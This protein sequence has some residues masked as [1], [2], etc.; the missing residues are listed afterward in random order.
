[1]LAFAEV[2][3]MKQNAIELDDNGLF[4]ITATGTVEEII[5]VMTM[6]LEKLKRIKDQKDNQH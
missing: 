3:A 2:M 5:P 4:Y 6:Q 1:M